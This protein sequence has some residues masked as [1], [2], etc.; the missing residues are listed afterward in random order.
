[1]EDLA[2]TTTNPPL[3]LWQLI[4]AALPVGAFH[5]SQGLEAAVQQGWVQDENS[6]RD[7]IAAGLQ[8]G[9]AQVDLPVLSRIWQAWHDALPNEVQRWNAH[10]RACRETAELRAE[11]DNMGVAL[12][13]LADAWDEPRP[14]Q[15]LGYTA[16]FAV[17]AANN[18]IELRDTLVGYAWAWCENLSLV[19]T[20]LV[21]LGHLSGQNML[22][23]L[24]GSIDEA[25]ERALAV[26]DEDIGAGLPGMW[27]ASVQHEQQYSRV[28]RS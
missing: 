13:A 4:S 25:T 12:M 8:H 20:K 17:L 14:Q 7:W 10:L 6:A 24:S 19:A 18:R 3:R 21:P 5:Y 16:M 26:A 22:R 2:I 9:I 28:F 23:Q 27:M 15:A 11:D 1:M